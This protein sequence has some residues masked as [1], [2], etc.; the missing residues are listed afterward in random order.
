MANMQSTE[1]EDAG[2]VLRF[3]TK[4]KSDKKRSR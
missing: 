2:N 4:S 1:D 3:I